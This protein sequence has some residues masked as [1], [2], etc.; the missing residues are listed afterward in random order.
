MK[1][2]RIDLLALLISLFILSSCKNQDG[3]GLNPD[4]ALNGTLLVD[5][6]IVVNTVPEDSVLTNGLTKTPLGYLNDPQVGTTE[7]NVAMAISLP[8]NSAY[9]PPTGTVT[10]DSAILVLRYN[11]G[12]Y[13]DSLSSKYKVNV[14]QLNEKPL[15]TINYYNTHPWNYNSS[16][17]VGTRVFNS[18]THTSFK[19][20]DIV[21]GAKDTLITVPAQ[22]RVPLSTSFV[23]NKMFGASAA[24]LAS[25]SV[26]QNEFK[27]LFVTMDKSQIGSGGN[28]M[29]SMDSSRIDVYYR[30]DVPDTTVVSFPIGQRAAEIKHTYIASV[31]AVINNQAASNNSFYIQGLAGLRTKISFPNLSSIVAQA[32]SD[33]VINR[34]ELVITPNIGS[35]IPFVAQPKITMYQLDISKQRT[36]LQDAST[37]DPRAQGLAIF[38]GYLTYKKD[39]HFIITGYIQ[40]LV[41]GRTKDYGTYLGAV[42]TTNTQ[43]VDYLATPQT[44]GRLIAAGSITNQSA[45]DYPYRIKLNIIY[46]KVTK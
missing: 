3:I 45:A 23:Q 37:S 34:A 2:L 43:S 35:T 28:F 32:G 21:T 29:L 18:R 1:F 27:G 6:N 33:I 25:N 19:I 26:F 44:G 22:L 16:V 12:F 42:D 10:I 11:D 17:L 20:T 30:T 5:D 15:A 38:G 46:T 36:L 24:A 13:G 40:D 31:Q 8:L 41:R 7:A 14:Y 39:Y 4:N 9:T